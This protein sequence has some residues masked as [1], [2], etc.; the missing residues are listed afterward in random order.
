[1]GDGP[2]EAIV[3]MARDLQGNATASPTPVKITWQN[4]L[5]FDGQTIT[6]NQNV[7]VASADSTL[8]CDRLLAKLAAPLKFGERIEQSATSF[9][10]IDC[11]GR[12]PIENLSRDFGGVTAHDRMELGHLTINQ[13]TGEIRGQGPGVIRSTRYGNGM[14]ALAGS[15]GKPKAA[16]PAA[17]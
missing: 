12:V 9:S 16:A 7:T 10:Q 13:Q 15:D 5:R 4:G 6:F 1:W 2:G 8:K 17:N 11:E 3:L 14:G